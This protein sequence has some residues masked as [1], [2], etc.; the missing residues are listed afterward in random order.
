MQLYLYPSLPPAYQPPNM[1]NGKHTNNANCYCYYAVPGPARKPAQA[2]HTDA[3]YALPQINTGAQQCLARI[4]STRSY[5]HTC[6]TSQRRKK[7]AAVMVHPADCRSSLAA[8]LVTPPTSCC[9][10]ESRTMVTS[11]HNVSSQ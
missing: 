4:T 8:R 10:S 1:P 2:F 5:L 9:C 3:D 11:E 7:L 6:A